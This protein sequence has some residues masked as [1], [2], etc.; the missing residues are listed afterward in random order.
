MNKNQLTIVARILAKDE[1][2]SGKIRTIKTD[3]YY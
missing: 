1:K 2:K 3:T